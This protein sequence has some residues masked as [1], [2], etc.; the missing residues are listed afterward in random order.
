MNISCSPQNEGG[1]APA[2]GV[3]AVSA[4]AVVAV[5]L[6]AKPVASDSAQA[7]FSP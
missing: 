1:Q 4:H 3:I 6:A 7:R 5:V 2:C